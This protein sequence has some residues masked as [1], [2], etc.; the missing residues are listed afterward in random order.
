MAAEVARVLHAPLD[1]IVVRKLGV[2][3]QPELA[4]GAVGEGRVRVVDVD[5]VD[6]AGVDDAALQSIVERESREVELRVERFRAGRP[7]VPLGRRVVIVVDDGVATGSTARAA[8]RVAR[9]A[10]AARVVMAVP[11]APTG[12]DE[13]MGDAA[14]QYVAVETHRNF[15]AVARFY[16]DFRQ[17][18]DAEVIECLRTAD[19]DGE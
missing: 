11:V 4:M 1:V 17:V 6:R 8:C 14:D 19:D 16:R 10:G 7:S 2:P 13:R 9:G 12:W 18:D 15:G 5:L 3:S